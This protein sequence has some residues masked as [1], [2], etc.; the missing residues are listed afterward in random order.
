MTKLTVVHEISRCAMCPFVDDDHETPQPQRKW[1]CGANY[2]HENGEAA[3]GFPRDL[4]S[5]NPREPPAWC[6][7]RGEDR[8][9]TFKPYV[10][11]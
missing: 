10:P 4:P 9:I 8:L 2:N 1:R 5:V 7:L 11:A 3:P 6:P